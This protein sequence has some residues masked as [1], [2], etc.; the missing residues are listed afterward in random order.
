MLCER[1]H[2][3]HDSTAF[4]MFIFFFPTLFLQFIRISWRH[5]KLTVERSGI[6]IALTD[7]LPGFRFN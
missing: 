2:L 4:D 6:E 1:L 7:F 3:F 5:R